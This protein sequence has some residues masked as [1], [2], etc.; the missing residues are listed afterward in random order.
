MITSKIWVLRS[1][2]TCGPVAR[3]RGLPHAPALA[4]LPFWPAWVRQ[5]DV[6]LRPEVPG[7][8]AAQGVG[9]GAVMFG[10][11]TKLV[12][13]LLTAS[14]PTSQVTI[15]VKYTGCGGRNLGAAEWES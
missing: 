10:D 13:T 15:K 9:Y 8:S 4:A 1:L 5:V 6:T 14:T 2:L 3:W 11:E 12:V 7:T